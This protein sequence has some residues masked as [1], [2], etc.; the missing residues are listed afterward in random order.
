MGCVDIEVGSEADCNNLPAGGTVATIIA[1]NFNDIQSYTVVDGRITAI[2]LKSGKVA[3]LFSGF[4]NDVKDSE[5]V[6]NPGIGLNQFKHL[7]GFTL[8]SRTQVQK[9]NIEKL[10]RGKFVF[11]VQLRGKDSDAYI[12]LGIKNGMAKVPE[13]IR[14]AHENGGYF[15]LNFATDTEDGEYE[16]KLP[17]S[18]GT[19]YGDAAMI[20]NNLL[21]IPPI[22]ITLE[23]NP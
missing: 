17:Q 16:P 22:L 1:I 2:V 5:E 7:A 12:V 18:L 11:I 6:I 13:A 9:N 15:L 20:I 23:I 8:Y 10:S 19:D 21:P 4:R 3:Y 14:N